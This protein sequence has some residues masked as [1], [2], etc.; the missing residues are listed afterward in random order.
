VTVS[1]R[2]LEKDS[3]ELKKRTEKASELV[4]LD[5]VVEKVEGLIGKS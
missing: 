3:V 5:G 4:P 1:P 2:T